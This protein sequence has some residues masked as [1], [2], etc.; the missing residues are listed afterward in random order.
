MRTHAS[1]RFLWPLLLVFLPVWLAGLLGLP[2]WTEPVWNPLSIAALW[3]AGISALFAY[4][5]AFA[6]GGLLSLG[7]CLYWFLRWGDMLYAVLLFFAAFLIG[8]TWELPV[9]LWHAYF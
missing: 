5:P 2:P 6:V 9:R 1:L 3:P 4:S 8:P 7:L